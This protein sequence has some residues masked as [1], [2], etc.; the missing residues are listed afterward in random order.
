MKIAID[1]E[2]TLIAEC[3]EFSCERGNELGRWILPNGLRTGARRLLRDLVRCGNT[4]TLYSSRKHKRSLLRL[5]CLVNRLPIRHIVTL[6]SDRKVALW[7]P[8]VGQDLIL[9]DNAQNIKTAEKLGV[10]GLQI[11]SRVP[12]W[13]AQV[14]QVCLGSDEVQTANMRNFNGTIGASP[15]YGM[16]PLARGKRWT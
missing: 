9:D 11:T 14:W 3:G 2:G 15:A 12:D 6:R 10:K 8:L 13:I 4:I 5:W 16:Q 7:P 1:L